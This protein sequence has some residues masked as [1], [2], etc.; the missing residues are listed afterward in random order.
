MFIISFYNERLC[1]INIL[2]SRNVCF[3]LNQYANI[4]Q[5]GPLE[6]E[7]P[8]EEGADAGA[9]LREGAL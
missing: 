2:Q 7:A 8:P 6:R 9:L 1:K 5:R 4:Y 3:L